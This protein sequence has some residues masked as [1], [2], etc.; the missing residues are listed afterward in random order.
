[1]VQFSLENKLKVLNH[2]KLSMRNDKTVTFIPWSSIPK[3]FL[4]LAGRYKGK[5]TTTLLAKKEEDTKKKSRMQ[6]S[7]ELYNTNEN[8]KQLCHSGRGWEL[9][10][11]CSTVAKGWEIE[12]TEFW[13]L[14]HTLNHWELTSQ[15]TALYPFLEV[16]SWMIVSFFI[17]ASWHRKLTSFLCHSL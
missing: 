3:S 6:N 10:M 13:S 9:L 12:R 15:I 2:Q 11:F 17:D 1:M 8:I 4:F 14:V 5:N 16:S 7:G